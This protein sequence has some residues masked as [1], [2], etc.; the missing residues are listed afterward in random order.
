MAMD[1][2]AGEEERIT[3]HELLL[4]WGSSKVGYQLI[5]TLPFNRFPVPTPVGLARYRE[6]VHNSDV[7]YFNNA[8]FGQDFLCIA[9]KLGSRSPPVISSHHSVI[10]QGSPL[11][12]EYVKMAASTYWRAFNAFHALNVSDEVGLRSRSHKPVYFLPIPV[13]SVFYRPPISRRRGRVCE[14]LILGR[15]DQQK[16]IDLVALTV[17]H[18]LRSAIGPEVRFTFAGAGPLRH[19]ITR[20]TQQ[21]PSQVALVRPNDEEKLRLLQASDFLLAP[22]RRETFGIVF[23]EALLCGLPIIA[24]KIS[25]VS[26]VAHSGG[27]AVE[28]EDSSVKSI[29]LAIEKGHFIW[30][31]Q[32]DELKQMRVR[33][34]K[35]ALDAFAAE[36]VFPRYQSMLLDVIAHA[37]E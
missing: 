34:R 37:H 2:M 32:D 16:G 5:P 6:L 17:R 24:P 22:S 36:I 11:H 28:I 26:E 25:G 1:W 3:R 27:A 31:R 15:L 9:A 21:F 29:A 33:A 10:Q 19:L 4:Q 20:L 23:A 13:D 18:I 35:L 12:D 8:Y 14:I 7:V 30:A